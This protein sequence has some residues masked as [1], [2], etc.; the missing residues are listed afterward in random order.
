MQYNA[1]HW[2]TVSATN[3]RTATAA[4]FAAL[5][6]PDQSEPLRSSSL[7]WLA[8]IRGGG[9]YSTFRKHREFKN[10]GKM[11]NIMS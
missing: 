8:I 1:T 5:L 9:L 6:G 3:L 7:I 2:S 11:G 10:Q 4:A